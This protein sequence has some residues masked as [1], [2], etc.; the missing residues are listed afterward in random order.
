[1]P[2]TPI[3]LREQQYHKIKAVLARLRL[4]SSA[5]VVLLIDK[6]GQQI[7]VQGDAGNLYPVSALCRVKR[8]TSRGN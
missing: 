3:L 8:L 2:D 4:D 6:D 7:A 5:R 1:M